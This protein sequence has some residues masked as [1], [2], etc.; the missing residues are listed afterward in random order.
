[1]LGVGGA[2]AAGAALGK[3]N[4]VGCGTLGTAGVAAGGGVTGSTGVACSA[5]GLGWTVPQTTP[6]AVLC[7]AILVSM[8]PLSTALSCSRSMVVQL[9][10]SFPRLT[11]KAAQMRKKK[12]PRVVHSNSDFR[13]G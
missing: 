10:P 8:S 9:P 5:P 13:E 7:G 3:F 1:V 6:E 4:G 12:I 11:M 2:G